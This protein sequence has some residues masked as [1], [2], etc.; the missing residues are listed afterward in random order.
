MACD[1]GVNQIRASVS[2]RTGRFKIVNY[3]IPAGEFTT[4]IDWTDST[5]ISLDQKS[6]M[7]L[8]CDD[9]HITFTINAETV[10]ALDITST[11]A[12]AVWVAADGGVNASV[13][14]DDVLITALP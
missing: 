12:D 9:T 6:Y 7:R 1:D 4:Y 3:N 5:A 10:A 8:L 11:A 13:F 14:V 2:S